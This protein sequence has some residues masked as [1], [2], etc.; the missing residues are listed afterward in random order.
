MIPPHD[1][2]SGHELP[3][4]PISNLTSLEL[5]SYYQNLCPVKRL[6][7]HSMSLIALSINAD[8]TSPP[9]WKDIGQLGKVWKHFPKLVT[10]I[11]IQ[12]DIQKVRLNTLDAFNP[13]L[14]LFH[15]PH[16][17]LLGKLRLET[18]SFCLLFLLCFLTLSTDFTAQN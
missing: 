16:I 15:H 1:G 2:T 18:F 8:S 17:G 7:A 13:K 9:Y 5:F 12:I 4:D 14:Y 11:N 10:G 3:K 6:Q